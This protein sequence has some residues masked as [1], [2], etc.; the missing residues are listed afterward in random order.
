MLKSALGA[1]G[2]VHIHTDL[3]QVKTQF[4]CCCRP[5]TD[6]DHTINFL[7]VHS[8]RFN[9]ANCQPSNNDNHDFI[10]VYMQRGKSYSSSHNPFE[11]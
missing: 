2:V 3:F 6:G 10:T 1:D 7:Q 11:N 9:G 5:R 8:C 4:C